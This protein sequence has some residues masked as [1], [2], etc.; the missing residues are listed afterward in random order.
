MACQ[1]SIGVEVRLPRSLK[2]AMIVSATLYRLRMPTFATILMR[3]ILSETQLRFDGQVAF[4]RL[5]WRGTKE[6][7]RAF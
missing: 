5:G 4:H 2:T 1:A 7:L 6:A 3:L